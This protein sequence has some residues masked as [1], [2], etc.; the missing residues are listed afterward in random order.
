MNLITTSELHSF[1]HETKKISVIHNSDID[2]DKFAII[3]NTGVNILIASFTD[4]GLPVEPVNYQNKKLLVHKQP[5]TNLKEVLYDLT[6]SLTEKKITLDDI[7]CEKKEENNL[8][9]I[10]DWIK[11]HVPAFIMSI[12]EVETYWMKYK[13]QTGSDV[14]LKEWVHEFSKIYEENETTGSFSNV[15]R[16]CGELYNMTV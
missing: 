15:K 9:T 13:D 12:F 3:K 5:V 7:L 16:C 6:K 1:D 2:L 4:F 14:T 8:A 11:S 10:Q